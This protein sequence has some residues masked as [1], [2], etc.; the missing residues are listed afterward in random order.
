MRNLFQSALAL[1]ALGLAMIG[2]NRSSSPDAS[3]GPSDAKI[4]SPYQAA[5]LVP[6]MT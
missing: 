3:E 1:F 5:F 2:C 4:A 6:G